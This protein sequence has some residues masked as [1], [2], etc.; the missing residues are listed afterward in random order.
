M[1]P[2]ERM[3]RIYDRALVSPNYQRLYDGSGYFNYGYWGSNAKT[4]QQACDALVDRLAG[5]IA[6][7][8][9]NI[10]DVA[11]GP[12]G[13]TKRLTRFY[14]AANITAINISEAQLAAGRERAP[15]CS[16]VKM[17]ATQLGF[18][19]GHFDAVICIEA[20]HHF[21]TRE[22]FF[23]EALRVLKPGGSLVLTDVLPRAFTRPWSVYLQLPL[24]NR[25]PDIATF[26]KQL[27]AA[28]FTNVRAEDATEVCLGGFRKYLARWP[29]SERRKGRMSFA[30][31]ILASA[32]T[33]AFA[34][35][36]GAICKAYLIASAQKPPRAYPS[37][38]SRAAIRAAQAGS[39]Q[40]RW[41]PRA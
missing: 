27:Q 34:A 13:A 5:R 33:A 22:V 32:G 15:G 18:P 11:C 20:A 24:A 29:E 14:P 30:K 28:G 6:R 10:L 19:D 4:Q 21:D 17:N 39:A 26:G 40:T 37:A 25:L 7:P 16:F 3:A 12:G 23:R 36:F 38:A 8:G 31:S 35:Y 1:T 2:L 9:G 41:S